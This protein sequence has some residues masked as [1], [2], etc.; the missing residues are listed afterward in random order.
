MQTFE[1]SL[2]VMPAVYLCHI[3]E[4]YGAGG[5]AEAGA[6]CKDIDS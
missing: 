6:E 1:R 3:L 4:E 2:W 5:E